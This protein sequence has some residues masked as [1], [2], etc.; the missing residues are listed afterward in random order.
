MSKVGDDDP[1]NNSQQREGEDPMS[2]YLTQ[3]ELDYLKNKQ[4]WKGDYYAGYDTYYGSRKPDSKT[5][6]S[7]VSRGLIDEKGKTIPLNPVKEK[8]DESK[9]LASEIGVDLDE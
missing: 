5:F 3:P 2:R 8:L 6:K 7:G 9:N 1:R 4:G